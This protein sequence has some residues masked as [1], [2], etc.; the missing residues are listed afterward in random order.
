[1]KEADWLD[2][3]MTAR[4]ATL[5]TAREDGRIDLVPCT[6]AHEDRWV[7]TAVDRKPKRTLEL[8]RL[9]NVERFPEVTLLAHHYDD[10]SWDALWWVR[11]RGRAVVHREGN[12]YE[13]ALDLLAQ[14]YGQYAAKRPKGAVIA[15]DVTEAVGWKA[16][17]A[18]GTK[19]KS[20]P[21]KLPAR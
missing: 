9:E 4:V 18:A 1:M 8:K 5:S 16:T 20:R 3:F 17:P 19:R 11:L 12:V 21:K 15:I 7:F 2:L 14:R 10:Q 6:F 13:Q